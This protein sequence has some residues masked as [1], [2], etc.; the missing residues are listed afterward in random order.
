MRRGQHAGIKD[1]DSRGAAQTG[2]RAA[3]EAS[4]GRRVHVRRAELER[5][6]EQ[7]AGLEA[8]RDPGGPISFDHEPAPK[9]WLARLDLDALT[10]GE[11][12]LAGPISVGVRRTDRIRVTGRNGAGKSTLLAELVAAAAVP[13]ERLLSLPQEMP[14]GRARRL[15]E[16]I[17]ALPGDRRGGLLA[18]V[19]RLGVDPGRLLESQSPSP[20]EA[21]KVMIAAGLATSAWLVVL[22]EPTNHLDLP[23]IERLEEALAAYPGALVI[24][25]HDDR[26]GASVTDIEWKLEGGRLATGAIGGAAF[27]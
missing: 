26:L 13:D 8:A 12:V 10:A 25:T 16:E 15:L 4:A 3:G 9:E 19:A 5:A 1:P 22:D 6:R 27:G 7:V 17:R 11:A 18:L 21:R 20:G 23:S 2:R 14:T 24:V